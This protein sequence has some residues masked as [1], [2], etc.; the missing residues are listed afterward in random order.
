MVMPFRWSYDN[1]GELD[2]LEDIFKAPDWNEPALKPAL[3][4]IL[5]PALCAVY[6]AT[7]DGMN[8]SSR[9]AVKELSCIQVNIESVEEVPS[10]FFFDDDDDDEV[11]YKDDLSFSSSSSSPSNTRRPRSPELLYPPIP[12]LTAVKERLPVFFNYKYSS[13]FVSGYEA[14]RQRTEKRTFGKDT[15]LLLAERRSSYIKRRR[16]M[17]RE[18]CLIIENEIDNA[19]ESKFYQL[20]M[21]DELEKTGSKRTV[22]RAKLWRRCAAMAEVLAKEQAEALLWK[23]RYEEAAGIAFGNKY[24][25]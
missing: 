25:H 14:E 8:A 23:R 1:Q 19:I 6:G 20:K 7:K 4:C 15:A 16:D 21:A 18:E 24:F 10:G 11:F 17:E 9:E 3:S 12:T 5:A 13:I 2:A 22:R